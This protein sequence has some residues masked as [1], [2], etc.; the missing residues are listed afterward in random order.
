MF[1]Y[2]SDGR[3]IKTLSPEFKLIPSI[4][5]E[6]SDAHVYFK[7]DVKLNGINEY[8]QKKQEEGIKFTT[9]EVFMAAILR[10]L[11]TRPALNRFIMNGRTY[12]RNHICISLTVKQAM[13]DSADESTIKLYFKGNENIFEVM[14]K[15]EEEL[16]IGKDTVSEN[17]TDKVANILGFVPVPIIRFLVSTIKFLD[18]HSLL[19]KWLIKAS[20]FH[21][22]C[23]VTNV[24]SLGI[25]SIYHHLYNFGTTSM[26]FAM[27]KKKKSYIYEDDEIK[28]EKV[29]NI[30]FVGDE[31]ICD[32][33]YYATSFKALCR[34]LAHPEVLETNLDEVVKDQK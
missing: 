1:G 28:E 5:R 34:I 3:K 2:R 11:A 15:I 23:Y 18:K 4:M 7:Q 19:P 26:F 22:S 14:K 29:I 32:G 33:F 20:P 21:T 12:A 10:I 17:S 16:A 31:R 27:G 6:R 8:I 25:D 24:G 13:T 9:M 30:G